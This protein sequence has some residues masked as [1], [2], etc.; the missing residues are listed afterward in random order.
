M[1]ILANIGK[2]ERKPIA[3]ATNEVFMLAKVRIRESSLLIICKILVEG[4][5]IWLMDGFDMHIYGTL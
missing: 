1:L 3:A 4:W 2:A 5:T